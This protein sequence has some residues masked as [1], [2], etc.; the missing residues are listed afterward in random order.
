MAVENEKFYYLFELLSW[1]KLLLEEAYESGEFTTD[2]DGLI[3]EEQDVIEKLRNLAAYH[4][5]YSKINY[6]FR[7][8]G[9]VRSDADRALVEE[10]SHHPLI[11]GRNTAISHR[12]ATICYYIQGFC[13]TAKVDKHTAIQKFT[14]VKQILDD[15]PQL[16]NDLT[17]RYMRALSNIMSLQIDLDMIVEARASMKAMKDMAEK[18]AFQTDDIANMVYRDTTVAELRLLQKTGDYHQALAVV[19]ELIRYME[20]PLTRLNKEQEL[21]LN[22]V[23]STT[24]FGAGSYREALHWVNKVLNDNETNLRQDIYGYA[25]VFNLVVHYE[26]GNYD[27]LEYAVKS[28]HRFLSKRQRDHDLEL[29]IISNMRKLG[30]AAM[31]G[32]EKQ[33]LRQFSEEV[34][35]AIQHAADQII[36]EHFNYPLWIESKLKEVT[37]AEAAASAMQR[38]NQSVLKA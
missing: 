34:E 23:I 3:K 11:I 32:N 27:L 5:L 8:G 6:V 35:S 21:V 10:I 13:A 29:V 22:N 16:R 36:L 24:Y 18:P 37:L 33:V 25:R 19:D 12:A 4:V 28:T 9:Y 7:S 1:E 17:N 20:N 2:L 30:K 26:L 38:R 15:H 14:K 31:E